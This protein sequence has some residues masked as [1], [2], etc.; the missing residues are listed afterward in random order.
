MALTDNL[1]AYW[2]LEEASGTRNDSHGSNHLTDVNTVGSTTGKVGTAADFEA[3]SSECLIRTD[4]TDLSTGDIDFTWAFW[5]NPESTGSF[6]VI[7]SKG[8]AGAGN[9]EYLAYIDGSAKIFWEV[10]GAS[11]TTAGSV[12]TSTWHFVVGWHDATNNLVG[13]SLDDTSATA[14]DGG[15]VDGSADFELGASTTQGLYFDGLIDQVGFWKRVL[16][17]GER[18]ALYNSGAGLSYAGLSAGGADHKPLTLLGVG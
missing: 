14:A 16:T 7:L 9:R 15:G 17:A 3:G 12:S 6:P 11:I 1:V 13:V 4:N 5:I 8:I 18:T 10:N 2:E